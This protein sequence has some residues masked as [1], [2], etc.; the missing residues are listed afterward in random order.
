M[1]N[2]SFRVTSDLLLANSLSPECAQIFFHNVLSFVKNVE[3]AW[4]VT[5]F[6]QL[7][8][9]DL[10]GKQTD[11]DGQILGV[12]ELKKLRSA[13][14]VFFKST[15]KDTT[16]ELSAKIRSKFGII[17]LTS[18]L[19]PF[20]HNSYHPHNLDMDT[21]KEY[22]IRKIGWKEEILDSMLKTL[23][24]HLEIPRQEMKINRLIEFKWVVLNDAKGTS[25]QN[26]RNVMLSFKV[27]DD[28]GDYV[29]QCID[30]TVEEVGF[31]GGFE[32]FKGVLRVNEGNLRW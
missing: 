22:C 19:L 15:E 23:Q 2:I 6:S 17:L 24:S 25:T 18:P 8:D 3:P 30:V 26:S 12:P 11:D 29:T 7:S 32:G 27:A 14:I 28:Q 4:D 1:L 13:L 5:E 9:Y 10:K 31:V 21:L 20:P 16:G